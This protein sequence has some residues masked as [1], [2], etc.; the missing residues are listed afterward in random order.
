MRR[1]TQNRWLTFILVLGVLA[2]SGTMIA[3]PSF[4]DGSD[5]IVYNGSVGG[6][7]AGGDPDG[8]AGPSK[9]APTGRRVAPGGTGYSLTSVGDGGPVPS[10]WVWRFQM[11]LRG[12]LS[13]YTRV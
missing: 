7:S 13:R 5:P 12:L 2:V 11:V 1:I 4:G 3:S 9:R 10:V 8:P 6:G